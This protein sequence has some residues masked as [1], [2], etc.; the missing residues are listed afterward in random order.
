MFAFSPRDAP[1]RSATAM[2]ARAALAT[3]R[4]IGNRGR[5][6]SRISVLRSDVPL[7]LRPALPK[8]PEPLVGHAPDVARVSLA[9]GAAGPLGGDD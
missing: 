4:R 5:I 9:S 6:L 7:V 2:T 3:E 8:G 1:A